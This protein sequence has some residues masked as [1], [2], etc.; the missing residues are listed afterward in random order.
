MQHLGDRC[1][2][3]YQLGSQYQGSFGDA[4]GTHAW[5]LGAFLQFDSA[6][7]DFSQTVGYLQSGHRS[8]S[9]AT[10]F[11]KVL[12]Y[13]LVGFGRLREHFVGGETTGDGQSQVADTLDV[14]NG[15]ADPHAL[16]SPGGRQH[17]DGP[18]GGAGNG[19]GVVVA[20]K[21][22][23]D[24]VR[25]LYVG[26]ADVGERSVVHGVVMKVCYFV[27]AVLG[28]PGFRLVA[29]GVMLM[30]MMNVLPRCSRNLHHNNIAE[31]A[32]FEVVR[33]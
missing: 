31:E 11:M 21:R 14:V 18:G 25:Q 3:G 15:A 9:V 27:A 20:Y 32:T 16:N 30:A 1:R 22:L 8:K 6:D 5:S 29:L 10:M 7:S 23:H 12:G 26:F 33:M 4:Q 17:S 19:S 2:R 28:N 24:R 13:V